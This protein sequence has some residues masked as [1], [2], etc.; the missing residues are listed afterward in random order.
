MISAIDL[1]HLPPEFEQVDP[2][3]TAHHVSFDDFVLLFPDDWREKLQTACLQEGATHLVCFENVD[4]WASEFGRRTALVVGDKQ[5]FT[6]QKVLQTPGCHLG[7]VPSRR[8]YP[9]AYCRT[10]RQEPKIDVAV[11]D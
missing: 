9:T 3:T 7:D 5:T 10:A 1:E 4:M 8:Q 6:L 2:V 11:K